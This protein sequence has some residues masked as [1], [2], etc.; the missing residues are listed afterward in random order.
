MKVK[1]ILS[2]LFFTVFISITGCSDKT[3][4]FDEIIFLETPLQIHDS[5]GNWLKERIT[6]SIEGKYIV[7]NL[8]L[9]LRFYDK[10]QLDNFSDRHNLIKGKI[11]YGFFSDKDGYHLFDFP[12]KI[13]KTPIMESFTPRILSYHSEQKRIQVTPEKFKM[14]H[15]FFISETKVVGDLHY[16]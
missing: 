7:D 11:F 2:L 14:I 16:E 8:V 4:E 10:E 12:I 9:K 5:N 13:S 1:T 6:V 3:E 15:S